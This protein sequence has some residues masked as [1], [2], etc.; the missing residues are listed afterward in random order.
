ME[1]VMGNAGTDD[2]HFQATEILL[3]MN[4]D[5]DIGRGN[6]IEKTEL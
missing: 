6:V 2:I 4:S 1:G 3:E 5:L